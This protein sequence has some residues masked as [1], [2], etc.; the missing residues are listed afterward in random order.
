MLLRIKPR[1]RISDA[2]VTKHATE[3]I[4]CERWESYKS[5]KTQIYPYHSSL[6]PERSE[7]NEEAK[8]AFRED[9][10]GGRNN[11]GGCNDSGGKCMGGGHN[12]DPWWSGGQTRCSS[13]SLSV[14]CNAN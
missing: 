1:S 6:F 3:S 5:N 7:G 2:L 12:G 8:I 14:R 11:F 4:G 9:E 13:S 10:L